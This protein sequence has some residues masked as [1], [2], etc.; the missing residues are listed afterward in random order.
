MNGIQIK[1]IYDY[2]IGAMPNELP[3]EPN[4]GSQIQGL[5]STKIR[6]VHSQVV[7]VH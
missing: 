4:T 2:V 5:S 3:E 7:P 1:P 6:N